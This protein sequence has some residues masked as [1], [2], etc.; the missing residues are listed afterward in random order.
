MLLQ[1]H[2]HRLT[3]NIVIIDYQQS[4]FH[5]VYTIFFATGLIRYHRPDQSHL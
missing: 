3:M 2:A 1:K 4:L 5:H